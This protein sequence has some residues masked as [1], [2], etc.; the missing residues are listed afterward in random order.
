MAEQKNEE[1]TLTNQTAAR[2]Q[3]CEQLEDELYEL[4]QLALVAKMFQD[5]V[6]VQTLL[7]SL[8]EGVI[9][10][11]HNGR[12]VLI[13]R[14]TEEMFGYRADEVVG[15]SLNFFLPER[16]SER[17]PRYIREFF[18]NPRIRSMGQRLDL[19]GKRG[20]GT[21]FPIEVSLSYLETEV[22]LL[23]LAF[24]ID[25]TLRKRAEEALKLRNEELNAFAHTVA[26]DIESAIR[27][28]IRNFW[29]N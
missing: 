18:K 23:G 4:N 11:D 8:A 27:K 1:I 21:E 7:E 14:P 25:I 9:V 17:H 22:G 24:V 19:M 2:G 12:I 26:H 16:Y 20:D 13:N 28:I 5:E 3:P 6:S 15:Q 10:C 29:L